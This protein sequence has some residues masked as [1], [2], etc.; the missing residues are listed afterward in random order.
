MKPQAKIILISHL[1][2][3]LSN[4]RQVISFIPKFRWGCPDTFISNTIFPAYFGLLCAQVFRKH[5]KLIESSNISM[6]GLLIT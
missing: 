2:Y 5:A 1:Y 4:T 6:P 3:Q